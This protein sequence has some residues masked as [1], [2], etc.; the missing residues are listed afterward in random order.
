[1]TIDYLRVFKKVNDAWTVHP[2]SVVKD[3]EVGSYLYHIHEKTWFFCLSG[4][5]V[6]IYDERDIPKEVKVLSLLV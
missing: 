1:M 3:W 5:Q 2:V 4:N 6:C